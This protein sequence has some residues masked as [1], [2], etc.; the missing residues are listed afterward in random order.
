MTTRVD[1]NELRDKVKVMYRAVAE[2]PQGEFHFEMGRVLAERLG[3]PA[4]ELDLVPSAAVP[5]WMCSSPRSRQAL[6][7]RSSVST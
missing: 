1:V 4:R 7:E 5:A 3:Y 2:A 6:T